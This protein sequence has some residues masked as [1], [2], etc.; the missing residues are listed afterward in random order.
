MLS[1]AFLLLAILIL[2]RDCLEQEQEQEAER[3]SRRDIPTFDRPECY[4]CPEPEGLPM[5]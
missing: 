2:I 5:S 4:L 3:I 1:F